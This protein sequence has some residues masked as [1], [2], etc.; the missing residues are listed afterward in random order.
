M[1][2]GRMGGRHGMSTEK[3]KDFKGTM[4]KLMGYLTQYKIGLLLVVIFAIGSTIFN[5]AGPKILG[6]ATT[7]LFHG[8]I[9][10]VSGGSGIDFDKIAKILIGLMCLYVCSALFSFIQ[11]YIMTGVSQKLTYR[12]RKE[13]SEKIDRLPMGYFDKMTHGE[14]LSRITNDVDTL[15]QSLNQSAT[16][17]ITSVATIIGVLVMMLSIS[18]LMTVIAILI[19]PLSM[20]LI[21]MIVK[22]SQRYFKEQQEYLG[23]VNGQVEEVYGGHN[24]VKA[25][26]KEDD[27]IDEFDRDND[28]LYRSAWKS[29]FLSG[30]MM[31]IMQFVGNLGYVAVVILGGYLAIKKTIEVG[32]IQ[33]FIQYVRNFTQPIQQVAQVANMLQ[34][35]AAASERVFEFLE[36]PEEEAAPENPVVLKN[37]EGAVEF[38]HVHFGYNPEHTIIHDFSVKVEP[39][40][41]IAI[42]GPTGAGKTTM[43]KLLMRF[44]DV[45]GGSIKVDGHDIREFDRGELRRMF[46]M[47]LQDT[48]LFKG[49]IEDNIRYGK[50]DATHEDVVKAADAAYAHRFI[51]TLPGGYGMELN[52]EA[53]NVSQ[54]QKQL[55]TIARAILA[56]PKILILD[57]A[58]SSVDTRTEV[59]IQKAM[60][61]LM[62]GRTSFIIAHRLSTIRD[63]DLILVMKEGDIVEMGRHEELLAK[64]GFYADLYNSQ[65]EQTA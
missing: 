58:T 17:V 2:R 33:S 1:P 9:S 50:L 55:L 62:K 36:E 40:Q 15:S 43:V 51:Q 13:I 49:S 65:F 7:E 26:N 60:D 61:N 47:V 48:W 20:G 21:G 45:S 64:N 8:L 12:M 56:D 18:P 22:R 57:E 19:L 30:M 10:K 5:I 63:A 37:P 28:R 16:Q 4:K 32:D 25:F 29:Q 52:E 59:R 23:Y 42:V 39:G 11:G 35:T 24:I 44:Y 46:G 31:P 14:I 27:V 6:K 53:S 41:K 54:G 3:A 34:S 38:E